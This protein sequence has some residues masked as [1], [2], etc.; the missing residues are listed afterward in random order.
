[1]EK[2]STLIE[3]VVVTFTVKAILVDCFHINSNKMLGVEGEGIREQ[4]RSK[5]GRRGEKDA[6]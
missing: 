1:M 4:V 5:D 6:K 3:K 2:K